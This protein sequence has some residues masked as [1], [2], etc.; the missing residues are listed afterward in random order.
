MDIPLERERQ[1]QRNAERLREMAMKNRGV[2]RED[3]DRKRSLDPRER[4]LDRGIVPDRGM[5]ERERMRERPAIKERIVLG[6]RDMKPGI[7]P[8]R[9]LERDIRT[10]ERDG[11]RDVSRQ[12]SLERVRVPPRE[13]EEERAVERIRDVERDVMVTERIVDTEREEL[14]KELVSSYKSALAELTFNSKPIITNLTII[15]GENVH[16]AKGITSTVCNHILEVP[17]EQKLPSL[18]LLDSIVKNIGGDYIKF[19]AARL[20]EVFVT[21]Y[22]HVDPATTPAMQHLFR[23]WRGV[24][25]P[26]PLR[27]IEDELEISTSTHS[28]PSV[29]SP[30][31]RPAENTLQRTGHGIHVNPKYLEAQ[32]Q[33]LQ[34][35]GQADSV[36]PES[37]GNAAIRGTEGPALRESSKGWSDTLG[38][39]PSVPVPSR[40]KR[41]EYS[42]PAYGRDVPFDFDFDEFALGNSRKSA[43]GRGM[44][45]DDA[46]DPTYFREVDGENFAHEEGRSPRARYGAR[47]GYDWRQPPSRGTEMDGYGYNRGPGPGRGAPFRPIQTP[48]EVSESSGRGPTDNWLKTDEEEY[49]WEDMSP[50]L[51]QPQGRDEERNLEGLSKDEWFAGETERGVTGTETGRLKRTSL[52]AGFSDNVNW[53]RHGPVGQIEQGQS[54]GDR[55]PIKD[56][57]DRSRL[58]PT[59]GVRD[60]E[61]GGT[62]IEQG[63]VGRGALSGS[64]P[65]THSG[66]P[67]QVNSPRNLSPPSQSRGRPGPPPLSVPNRNISPTARN[68]T[69]LFPR[70][71]TPPTPSNGVVHPV[72][73]SSHFESRQSTRSSAGNFTGSPTYNNISPVTPV[74]GIPFQNRQQSHRHPSPP[75]QLPSHQVQI[76]PMPQLSSSQQQNQPPQIQ[77]LQHD[78]SG[79]LQPVRHQLQGSAQLQNL[80]PQSGA[81]QSHPLQHITQSQVTPSL[82]LNA[83][84]SVQPLQHLTSQHVVPL[85]QPSQLPGLPQ[86]QSTSLQQAS[87]SGHHQQPQSHLLQPVTQQSAPLLPMISSQLAQSLQQLAQQQQQQQQSQAAPLQQQPQSLGLLTQ[88]LA[89]VANGTSSGSL[90]AS[91]N[92]SSSNDLLTAILQSGLIPPSQSASVLTQPQLAPSRASSTS[93]QSNPSQS[94]FQGQPPLPSGPPPAQF[95]NS[96]VL[97]AAGAAVQVSNPASQTPGTHLNTFA[98]Q[99]S[100]YNPPPLPPGPPPASTIVGSAGSQSTPSGG[101]SSSISSLLSSLVAHGVI[102]P[103]PAPSLSVLPVSTPPSLPVP[104]SQVNPAIGLVTMGV[105][106]TPP[107]NAPIS[108]VPA[109]V[110]AA[111]VTPLIVAAVPNQEL[112]PSPPTSKIEAIGTEFK[113]EILRERHEYV[114]EALYSDFPRQCKTCGLRFKAQ[115]EHSK[116]MDWHVSRNRRQ[117]SQKKISRKWFVST[118]EWLSGTGAA[119]SEFAPSFFAEESGAKEENVEVVAVPED[120]NQSACALCGEPFEDFYSDETDE[121]M[122]KGAV[123]LNVPPGG[124]TEGLDSSAL[125]PIV[126]LK[127][128]TESAETATADFAEDDEEVQPEL[129]AADSVRMEVDGSGDDSIMPLLTDNFDTSEI[130]E[131]RDDIGSRRKRTRY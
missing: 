109:P 105:L 117:K 46:W 82:Q 42:E 62:A 119:A 57:D 11:D 73:T 47:N 118:K 111:V 19:F 112:P 31:P 14:L 29:A 27:C 79:H 129:Q 106:P 45:R 81:P 35:T 94:A 3:A 121:W 80:G 87:V 30:P 50:R 78:Q 59:L 34:Q 66:W 28:G 76:H 52:D 98:V 107:V 64:G 131:E 15:A 67:S 123:Y 56:F 102:A 128:K 95:S 36:A 127:C 101:L 103:V 68:Q 97:P 26:V 20:P 32:R 39:R 9:M 116:H 54:A 6:E 65:R 126:H 38:K 83:Q 92:Q 122:Y 41:D 60:R 53:R 16:A 124:S 75:S 18:Y 63:S 77:Q 114:L 110:S 108:V 85:Q 10:V 37:N 113:Q 61:S 44:D 99:P 43:P 4:R 2:V 33:R 7:V 25:P 23:T 5:V 17:K 24:F 40:S 84:Q 58:Q 51:G 70:D 115:D 8:E 90:Q 22:R 12:V 91:Q 72:S 86:Q 89:P 69:N 130:K 13:R 104:A 120:E 55:P 88:V 71:G 96:V 93:V 21:A 49:V 74:S 100:R 48:I 1:Q 125:G